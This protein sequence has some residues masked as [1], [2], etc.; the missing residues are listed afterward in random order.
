MPALLLVGC[1]SG[2]LSDALTRVNQQ[3]A[4]ANDRQ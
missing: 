4:E 3:L 2:T 1:A